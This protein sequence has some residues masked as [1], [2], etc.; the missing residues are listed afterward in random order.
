VCHKGVETVVKD[1][2]DDD[3]SKGVEAG[4]VV[5]SMGES[6]RAFQGRCEYGF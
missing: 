3:N 5:I 1:R 6:S 4:S 2:S